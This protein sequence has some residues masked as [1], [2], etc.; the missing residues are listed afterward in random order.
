MRP[1]AQVIPQWILQSHRTRRH[2]PDFHKLVLDFAAKELVAEQ[3]LV[4]EV[5][6]AEKDLYWLKI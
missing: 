4:E 2:L 5:L 3:G 1:V 6:D